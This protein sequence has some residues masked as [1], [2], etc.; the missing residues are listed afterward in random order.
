MFQ[1]ARVKRWSRDSVEL[2]LVLAAMEALEAS[3]KQLW[4]RIPRFTLVA[5]N[6]IKNTP[7]F[8]FSISTAFTSLSVTLRLLLL[9]LLVLFLS[10]DI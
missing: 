5:F 8:L 7:F 9:F 4:A 10:F 6:R 3:V 2:P 1:L